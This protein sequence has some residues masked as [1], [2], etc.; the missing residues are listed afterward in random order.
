MIHT[1]DYYEIMEYTVAHLR[2]GTRKKNWRDTNI[3]PLKNYVETKVS[4]LYSL[5]L[6]L[7]ILTI[8]L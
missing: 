5:I 6:R 3:S 7:L 8:F 2:N 4:E 1:V